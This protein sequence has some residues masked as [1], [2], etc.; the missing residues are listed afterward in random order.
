[1][2]NQQ[3]RTILSPDVTSL[4]SQIYIILSYK[5]QRMFEAV[6]RGTGT[7]R[8]D[9]DQLSMTDYIIVV[10]EKALLLLIDFFESTHGT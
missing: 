1:M 6:I 9:Y 8:N 4:T 2:F 7:S 3:I 10:Y 5:V